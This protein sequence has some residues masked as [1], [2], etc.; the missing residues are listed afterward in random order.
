LR[1]EVNEELF[2]DGLISALE[3]RLSQVTA[4]ERSTP[5]G[6]EQKRFAFS[7]DSIAP[8]LAVKKAEVNRLRAQVRLR[9]ADLEALQVRAGVKGVLQVLPV[10]VGAQVQPGANPA[11][12][13]DPTRLKAEV[14]I[15]ETQAKDV[16]IGQLA[17]IDTRNGVVTGRVV[18][19][20]PAVQNGTVLVE[21]TMDGPLP[22]GARP[23][24]S[25]D[26]TVEL[27]RLDVLY[28]GRPA[29]GQERSTVGIFKLDP[30]GV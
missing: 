22:R 19:V 21:V 24:L 1:S 8:Q 15:A 14:R 7:K 11:R 5:N 27:E 3:M 26:G 29:F 6:I 10:E 25:I 12:V 9:T 16:L 28:V 30:A 2:K 23:D 18:L 13:A 20:D 4:E 17:T